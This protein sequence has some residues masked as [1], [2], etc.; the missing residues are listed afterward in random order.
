MRLLY[1]DPGR[2][3]VALMAYPLSR[4]FRFADSS[5]ELRADASRRAD[6]PVQAHLVHVYR[7]YAWSLVAVCWLVPALVLENI[8]REV[9]G[10]AAVDRLFA[11]VM[12][13]LVFSIANALLSAGRGVV[14]R[15]WA[16]RVFP[17]GF[18]G[19]G[20]ERGSSDSSRRRG[21]ALGHGP[22]NAGPIIRWLVHPSTADLVAAA[23]L[24]LSF[25]W[26]Y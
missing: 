26:G 7:A 21:G 12:F 10:P 2:F 19:K 23:F 18:G 24:A 15:R 5:A 9:Y 3:V 16:D 22:S 17:P 8:I 1:K 6:E 25:A 13:V 4:V 11:V 20:V 14:A